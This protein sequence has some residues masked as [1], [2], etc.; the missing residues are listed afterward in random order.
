MVYIM[1]RI[2]SPNQKKLDKD[3]KFPVPRHK[4]GSKPK[5]NIVKKT[6]QSKL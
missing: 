3:Y 4:R 2:Y 6:E 5:L 1:K